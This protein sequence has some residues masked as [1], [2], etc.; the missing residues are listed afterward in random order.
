MK[1]LRKTATIFTVISLFFGIITVPT[2]AL[3]SFFV[4]IE[5]ETDNRMTLVA[6]GNKL[7]NG[8]GE[9]VRLIGSN[10]TLDEYDTSSRNWVVEEEYVN[11]TYKRML[12]LFNEFGAN[13]ARVVIDI[14]MWNS[15]DPETSKLYRDMVDYL[16]KYAAKE[17]KYIWIDFHGGRYGCLPDKECEDFWMEV[18]NKYKN[19]PNVL[20]GIFNEPQRCDWDQ[21]YYGT[22]EDYI[23][24]YNDHPVYS[25]G[26]Q[27]LV[28]V[29][30]K[31]GANNLII[32]DTIYFSSYFD[33]IISGEYALKDTENGNGIMYDPHI[34]SQISEDVETLKT[35]A[36]IYPVVIGE[37]N[38]VMGHDNMVVQM[39]YDFFDNFFE[40][41][42][43]YQL[44][45]CSW[46]FSCGDNAWNMLNWTDETK[47]KM[48]F[49]KSGKYIADEINRI[50][51]TKSVRL[52]SGG[53]YF[54]TYGG[55]YNVSDISNIDIDLRNID[56]IE[57]ENNS[58]TYI[59]KLYEKENFKGKC[60]TVY[61][62]CDD[63]KKEG[64]DFKPMSVEI[65]GSEI[66]NILKNCRVTANN[67]MNTI[68]L[69]VDGTADSWAGPADEI[70]II[71]FEL[72]D[73]Y[74]LTDIFL[75]TSSLYDNM[76]PKDYSY[77]VSTDGK[78]YHRIYSIC[79]NKNVYN[80]TYL[81]KTPAKYF[82]I[83]ITKGNE[84]MQGVTSLIELEINGYKAS[85]LQVNNP[86]RFSKL[87]IGDEIINIE[88]NYSNLLGSNG[89]D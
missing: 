21:W 79:G 57:R 76:M 19:H 39:D 29:I 10:F 20:F 28:N 13:C 1:N 33:G 44:S 49:T 66:N 3:P 85:D 42:E 37:F 64:L 41:A 48:D 23:N 73:Y 54:A 58:K 4:P 18:A 80:Y 75:W 26:M 11:I 56:R 31:T 62:F 34:Y 17:N 16:V 65:M 5:A 8:Y 52:F 83:I 45:Y 68:E 6:E 27:N 86:V 46:A 53:K 70:N 84:L 69:L 87:K 67:G 88:N 35:L 81:K 38:S 25:K 82:R 36:E 51:K 9:T 2:A 24:G 7:V 89:D 77:S 59:I 63:L 72:D 74:Y 61:N 30:R 78:N 32:A 47:T 43:L 40:L 15:E 22:G 14:K 12:M 55:K 50:N 60:F 71:T